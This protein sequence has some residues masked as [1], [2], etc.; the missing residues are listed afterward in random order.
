M[1]QPKPFAALA[2]T[3]LLA[4]AAPAPALSGDQESACGAILCLVGG[5]GVAECAGYLARYFAITAATPAA[6]FDRRLDFLNL[7]PATDLAADVRPMIASYGATCQ[8][9][10]LVAY[11]NQQIRWCGLR[12]MDGNS[13]CRPR[14][15]EWRICAPFYDHPVTTYEAPRLREQC[16]PTPGTDG[17]MAEHC[18]YTWTL[19]DGAVP[20]GG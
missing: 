3:L 5:S 14:G 19:A 16:Q 9:T 10:Q 12:N 11:L 2:A 15:D 17:S 6:L 18:T 8:P 4:S 13:N 1:K 20:V 7:C